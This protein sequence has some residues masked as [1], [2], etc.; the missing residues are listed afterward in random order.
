MVKADRVIVLVKGELAF[1]GKPADL[2]ADPA[3]M[4][5]T[6]GV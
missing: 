1:T 2:L 5:R 6:L 3:L 4:Q